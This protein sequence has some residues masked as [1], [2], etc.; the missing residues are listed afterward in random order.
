M[1]FKEEVFELALKERFSSI[2]LQVNNETDELKQA[3]A[4]R[5]FRAIKTIQSQWERL[6]EQTKAIEVIATATKEIT[7]APDEE[8][9]LT[10]LRFIDP[11]QKYSLNSTKSQK[12]Y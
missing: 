11:N 9:L 3:K 6:Q 2:E 5:S 12:I 10:F 1:N 4:T 7:T 8:R